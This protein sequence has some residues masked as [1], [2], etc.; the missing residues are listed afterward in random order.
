MSHS[1][2]QDEPPAARHTL[3][4]RVGFALRG[5]FVA[6]AEESNF[7]VYFLA[8]VAAA[9]LGAYLGVSTERWALIVLCGTIV[10]VAEL[11]N[12]SIEHL[13]RAMTRDKHPEI[14]DAL[15]IASGAVLAAGVGAAIV[16]LIIL[17]GPLVALIR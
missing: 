8:C 10:I 12:S 2:P 6:V 7:V 15:D 13:A 11:F 4:R 17:S 5:L 9:A 1:E 16:G 14:R 3:M